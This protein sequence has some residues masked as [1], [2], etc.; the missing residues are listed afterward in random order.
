MAGES[1][2]DYE[3]W[4]PAGLVNPECLFGKKVTYIRRKREAA[5]YNP[6]KMERILSVTPC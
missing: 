5:C 2:S 6:D 4:T 3:L 1:N